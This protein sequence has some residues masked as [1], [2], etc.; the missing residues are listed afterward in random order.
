MLRLAMMARVSCVPWSPGPAQTGAH[1]AGYL[2]PL[3]G[4]GVGRVVRGGAGAGVEVPVVPAAVI[5]CK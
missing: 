4:P 5:L 1:N 2:R 3:H